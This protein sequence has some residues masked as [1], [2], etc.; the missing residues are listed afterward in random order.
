MTRAGARR[1]I[2]WILVSQLAAAPAL[3]AQLPAGTPVSETAPHLAVTAQ[4]INIGGHVLRY[5]ATAGDEVLR[6]DTGKAQAEMF[7]VAYTE[8]NVPDETK[9]PLT[10]AFNG[11][12]GASSVLLNLGAL[13]PKYV[14]LSDDGRPLSPTARWVDNPS[15]WLGFT[16]L[17]FIDAVGTGF[18]RAAPGV[19]DATFYR[20]DGDARSFAQ[21][22]GLYVTTNRR[23]ASPK[24]VAGE[25]YGG[26]RAIILARLLQNTGTTSLNGLILISPVIDFETLNTQFRNPSRST[27][28]A[29]ALDIPTYAATAWYHKKLGP[30]LPAD[31]ESVV[32]EAERWSI[33]EY[34]PALVEGDALTEGARDGIA[35][36][37]SQYTG[38]PEAVILAHQL[39]LLPGT[40]RQELLRD[41]Q[42]EVSGSDGRI[43]FD[44]RAASL[45][46]TDA[47][48]KPLGSV[49]ER[50][51]QDELGYRANGAYE[52]LSGKVGRAWDWSVGGVT[53]FLNVAGDLQQSLQQNANMRVLVTLGYYDLT[54]PY[55]GTD[56]AL[57]HLQ[58]DPATQGHVISRYYESGHM[59]YT[60]QAVLEK[61]T[62]DASAFVADALSAARPRP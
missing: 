58:L 36:T 13:G 29:Y 57:N 19:P 54:V 56:Y 5:T 2:V 24:F 31:L 8:Q 3:A 39:R 55:A 10:F 51:A 43:V 34:L 23:D 59:I 44:P 15:T 30:G 33:T 17:V 42:L 22:I 14:R 21:F 41:R 60:S 9:R 35:R 6:D 32:R 18:S 12:P 38:V 16:D 25:S 48:L 26:T 46:T 50:Y 11:G 45:F 28:L 20:P 52:A 62:A 53:G 7:F 37:L 4:S 1:L 40:F 47:L 61:F 27:D 49:F